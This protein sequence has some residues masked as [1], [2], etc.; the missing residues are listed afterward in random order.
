MDATSWEPD[1]SGHGDETIICGKRLGEQEGTWADLVPNS[2][3]KALLSP[4]PDAEAPLERF[5]ATTVRS[6][7]CACWKGPS[8]TGG[9][10]GSWS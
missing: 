6:T 2:A 5:G 9:K 1:M 10:K 7:T 8:P 4:H 3:V